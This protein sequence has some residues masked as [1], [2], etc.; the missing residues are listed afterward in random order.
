MLG[1][2]LAAKNYLTGFGRGYVLR[3]WSVISPRRAP[4][5]MARELVIVAGQAAIDRN[6]SG[7]RG[8]VRGWRARRPRESRSRRRR[9]R[10]EGDRRSATTSR[11]GCLAGAGWPVAATRT[12]DQCRSAPA[13]SE[14]AGQCLDF[15]LDPDL[16]RRARPGDRTRDRAGRDDVVLLDQD[17]VVEARCG[18]CAP[19]P[20]RT[21]YFCAVRRPGSVLRVSRMRQLVPATAST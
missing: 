11:A 8:R 2:G 16:R 10:G 17:P 3:K 6:L 1:S 9:R 5:V 12:A 13:T 7:L 4:G 19:P 14:V 20:Q 15:D 18:D 21:A